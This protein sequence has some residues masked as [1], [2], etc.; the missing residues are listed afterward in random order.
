MKPENYVSYSAISSYYNCSYFYYLKYIL[1]E[2]P[3]Q[4]I[5]DR[6]YGRGKRIHE[7][8][9]NITSG[10]SLEY[11]RQDL[12]DDSEAELMADLID[13]LIRLKMINSPD[14]VAEKK[15]YLPLKNP[16]TDVKDFDKNLLGYVDI[17]SEKLWIELKT[18]R[19]WSLSKIRNHKQFDLYTLGM[20]LEYGKLIPGKLLVMDFSTNSIQIEHIER[21]LND[22]MNAYNWIKDAMEGIESF[23]FNQC[24]KNCYMCEFKHLCK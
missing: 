7:A 18:G 5:L 20:Y 24:R 10:K 3:D 8:V 13:I 12:K 2:K 14:V 15:I 23:E 11:V 21:S 4:N 9:E 19:K 16:I 1:E 22:I 6:K 17:F